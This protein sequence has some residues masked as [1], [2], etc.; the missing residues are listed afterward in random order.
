MTE[1]RYTAKLGDILAGKADLVVWLDHPRQL[2]MR[3]VTARTVARRWRLEVLWNGNVC[4]APSVRSVV[5]P[6]IPGADAQIVGEL[7]KNPLG[8]RPPARPESLEQIDHTHQDEHQ[9]ER[10]TLEPE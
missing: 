5:A 1:R 10:S 9:A 4:R 7:T 2:V 8:L 6:T 3:Q